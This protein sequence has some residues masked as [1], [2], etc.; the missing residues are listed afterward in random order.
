[1]RPSASSRRV[2][3]L[4]ERVVAAQIGPLA[5]EPAHADLVRPVLLVGLGDQQHVAV[6]D[7]AAAREHREGDGA[8]GRL[9]LH[10]E[11]ATAPEVA[12]AHLARERRHRPVGRV[13]V[14]DVGVAGERERRAGAAAAHPRDQVGAPRIARDALALHAV[15]RE[16]GLE[17][18]GAERLV[19]RRIG[20]V[21]ADQ[22]A[23]QVDDLVEQAV[24][25]LCGK[26]FVHRSKATVQP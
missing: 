26:Q 11:R 2:A 5:H 15:A 17:H 21:D 18:L 10:V 14:D 19:A 12:V 13:G 3:R 23:R 24:A 1:M 4:R 9:A 25:E 8:R 20:R 22:V 16:I 6:R 7:V